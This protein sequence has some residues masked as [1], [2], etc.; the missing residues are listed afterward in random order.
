MKK[1]SRI[2]ASSLT[3]ALVCA[4]FSSLIF[5]IGAIID[6]T[7][8]GEA[9]GY[10]IFVGVVA[11]FIGAAIGLVVSIMNARVLGGA[12]IGLLGTVAVVAFYVLTFS[13]PGQAMQ[14]LQGSWIFVVVLG[15]PTML[16]GAIAAL[17]K[18]RMS[19]RRNGAP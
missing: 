3:G 19:N 12:V 18:K 9:I 15:L 10:A 17:V 13:R 6:G 2:L 16:A 8:T 11:F 1:L 4:F 5:F 7:S 14:F